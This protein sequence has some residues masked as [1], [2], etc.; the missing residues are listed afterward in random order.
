MK[1]QVKQGD[2]VRVKYTGLPKDVTAAAGRRRGPRPAGKQLLEFVAGS[3]QVIRGISF[4]VVGMV[5]GE[6]KRL[7][8][9]PQDAFGAVRR[10]LFKEVP[11]GSFPAKLKLSVGKRLTAVGV[12]TGRRRKVQVAEI[13]AKTVVIDGNHPLAG[14]TVEVVV[15]LISL[16]RANSR[17]PRPSTEDDN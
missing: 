15:E 14:K 5:R 6:K 1:T 9:D 17:K 2:Q 16:A 4:G 3:D 7:M 8:L 11:L 12:S 10:E 13:N